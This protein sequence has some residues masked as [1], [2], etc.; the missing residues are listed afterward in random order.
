MCEKSK[1]FERIDFFR[2][3]MGTEGI[4][5]TLKSVKSSFFYKIEIFQVCDGQRGRGEVSLLNIMQKRKPFKGK[6]F[7][8]GSYQE[9]GLSRCNK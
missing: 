4:C 9:K 3:V 5:M 2:S 8:N 7:K 1:S 6:E